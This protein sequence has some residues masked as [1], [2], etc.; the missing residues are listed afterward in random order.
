MPAWTIPQGSVSF[1]AL[2]GVYGSDQSQS[3]TIT[4]PAGT[5]Q[6]ALIVIFDYSSISGL[7]PSA[8]TPSGYTKFVDLLANQRRM[9]FLYKVADGTEGGV[10]VSLMA[11]ASL[12]KKVVVFSTGKTSPTITISTP[13]TEQTNGDPSA[14]VVSASAGTGSTVVICGM[15]SQNVFTYTSTES[16]TELYTS[17]DWV[18][19]LY[20]ITGADNT[21]N[22]SD[23]GTDN[24]CASFY[25]SVS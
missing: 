3:Q 23:G 8:V 12:E 5:P 4:I 21:F 10:A 14:Q 11:G 15:A 13:A 18:K 19:M 16:M 25:I 24:K 9:T 1:S 20:R 6:G 2:L 22:M 7:D 17:R